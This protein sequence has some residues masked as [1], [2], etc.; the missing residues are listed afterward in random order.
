MPRKFIH[1]YYY[2]FDCFALALNTNQW[3]SLWSSACALH[4]TVLAVRLNTNSGKEANRQKATANALRR[5][6]NNDFYISSH[7]NDKQK[8]FYHLAVTSFDSL[9]SKLK[10][11]WMKSNRIDSQWIDCVAEK[12]Q[13]IDKDK[14]NT[15][16]KENRALFL[17]AIGIESRLQCTNGIPFSRIIENDNWIFVWNMCIVQCRLVELMKNR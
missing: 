7:E 6:F 3:C 16:L 11:K 2:L 1:I 10:S 8:T 12:N 13:P 5:R 14:E 9:E 17:A 15:E 4:R